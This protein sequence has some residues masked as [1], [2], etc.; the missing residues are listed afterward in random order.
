MAWRD[1]IGNTRTMTAIPPE[2]LYQRWLG[3]H[4]PALRRAVIASSVGLIVALVLV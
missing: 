2:T 4:A 3:W 1:A